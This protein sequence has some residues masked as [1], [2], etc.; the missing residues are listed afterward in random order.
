MNELVTTSDV[1]DALGGTT[2]VARLTGRKLAAVSNWRDKTSFP[3]A[4]FLVMQHA[5]RDAGAKAPAT[6]WNML[7]PTGSPEHRTGAAA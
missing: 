5:L 6:L 3:P 7:V 1:I 2:R 4:T